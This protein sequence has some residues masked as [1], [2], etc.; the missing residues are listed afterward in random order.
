MT[1]IP[2]GLKGTVTTGVDVTY[3]RNQNSNLIESIESEGKTVNDMRKAVEIAQR[4]ADEGGDVSEIVRE[5]MNAVDEIEFG[6]LGSKYVGLTAGPVPQSQEILA[7][8]NVRELIDE[9]KTVRMSQLKEALGY[10]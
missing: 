1:E 8:D 4:I 7:L 9:R 3:V 5:L 10:E 6:W 2:H